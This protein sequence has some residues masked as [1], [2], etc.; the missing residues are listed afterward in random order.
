MVKEVHSVRTVKIPDN[1]EVDINDM[2]KKVVVRGPRGTL[3]KDFS[4]IVGIRLYK[5]DGEV[6]VERYFAGRREKALVGTLA[7]HIENMILGVTKGFRYKLKIMFSHFPISVEIKG[8]TVLIKNFL[9]EKAPRKARI[10]PGVNVRVE[11]DD[12]IVEGNDIEMVGQTAA[13]IERACRVKNLDRR[14]FL[15]G[16]YI[17]ERG[18]I[19]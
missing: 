11:K 18:V 12:V 8:D 5:R 16:I 3:E 13:N 1:V 4:H 9:G 19:E 14:V 15:D 7:S 6:V 2:E 10:M 17:Y